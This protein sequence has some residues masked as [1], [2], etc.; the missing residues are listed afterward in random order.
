MWMATRRTEWKVDWPRNMTLYSRSFVPTLGTFVR[1][2]DL[3]EV[4][5]TNDSFITSACLIFAGI[6]L[7][8]RNSISIQS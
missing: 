2:R 7:K 5:Q 6:Q 4:S 8:A 1:A 3:C